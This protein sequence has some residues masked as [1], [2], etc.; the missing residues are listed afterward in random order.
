MFGYLKQFFYVFKMRTKVFCL[1]GITGAGKTTQAR[2]IEQYLQKKGESFLVI[3]EK[4]YEPFKQIVIDWHTWGADLNF[5]Y[6]EI[7]RFAK[8][9][10]ETYRRHFIP[11]IGKVEYLIFDRGV[12]T[13]GVYQSGAELSCEEIIEINLQEGVIKPQ[14]G[15]VFICSPEVAL[16]RANERRKKKNHYNLPS[17]HE[18][19]AEI[20]KRRELYLQLCEKYPELYLIDITE[21][22]K[23]DIF[24]EIRGILKL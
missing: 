18:A 12:Y 24:K 6:E 21:R 11:L 19:L 20:T 9:K 17:M 3:N 16:E 10:A 14:G 5:S 8:A 22:T 4:E 15:L 2:R 13:S 23:E 1:E 7:V